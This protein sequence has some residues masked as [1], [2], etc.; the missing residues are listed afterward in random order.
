MDELFSES[1]QE[2]IREA[3]DRAEG[4]TSGEIVPYVVGSSDTYAAAHWSSALLG[5]LLAPV[6]ALLAYE[7]LAIWGLPIAVWMLTP[8]LVG[9]AVGYLAAAAIPVWRRSLIGDATL[10]RRTRR[11]AAVAFLEEEVFKTRA[12]TGVLIFLSLFEHRVV[13]M[14]DEG[15]NRAIEAGEWQRIVDGVVAG[16]REGKPADAL[17]GAIRECGELLEERGVAIQP[18]DT[19]ELSDELRRHDS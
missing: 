6:L 18:D 3:V 7:R 5:A 19:D 1:A 13:V 9:A 17:V 16:I 15:I 11:R 8:V 10:D 12:R 4:R 2:R 14:G